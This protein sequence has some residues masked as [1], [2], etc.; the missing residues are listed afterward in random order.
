MSAPLSTRYHPIALMLPP[1]FT[2]HSSLGVH[3]PAPYP[4]GTPFCMQCMPPVPLSQGIAPVV[5]GEMGGF[6]DTPT[7]NDPQLLDKRWQDAL[8]AFMIE[9]G[10]GMFYFAVRLRDRPTQALRIHYAHTTLALMVVILDWWLMPIPSL[11]APLPKPAP[12]PP[13][14]VAHTVWR[15]MNPGSVDTG[16]LLD[17]DFTTPDESKLHLLSQLPTTDVLAARS[18][19]MLPKPPPPQQM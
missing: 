12:Y 16:G 3:A 19:S 5:I 11:L 2:I 18:R 14:S 13:A 15:Q 7:E 6:Y 10:I 9:R 4:F 17:F 1:S 8:I